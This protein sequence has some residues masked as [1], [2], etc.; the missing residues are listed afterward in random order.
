V[1]DWLYVTD[2]CE[3]IWT[4]IQKGRLGETYNIGGH[5]EQKNIDVVHALIRS[6]AEA[7]G[8]ERGELEK[9]ITYVT[10]RPGHDARYAIDASKI[11]RE[12]GWTPK[13]TFDT[14][15]QK[16]VRWYLDNKAWTDSVRSGE[17]RKWI[18]QNY[19]AR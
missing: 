1:R 8:T 5:N 13:E 2:H 17:Y 11:Q 18:D 12:L 7:T 4:V 9:L 15:L 14:G 6:V 3:A 16:T 10:D 19:G